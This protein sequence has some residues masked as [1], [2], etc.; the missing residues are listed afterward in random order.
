MAA[1]AATLPPQI[2]IHHHATDITPAAY[3]AEAVPA[4]LLEA[5][6]ESLDKRTEIRRSAREARRKGIREDNFLRGL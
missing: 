6:A 3:N 2:P 5:A 1:R 4:D